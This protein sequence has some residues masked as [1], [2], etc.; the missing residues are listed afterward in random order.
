MEATQYITL[1]SQDGQLT[2]EPGFLR[3]GMDTNLRDVSCVEWLTMEAEPSHSD[4]I[5]IS[6]A[7]SHLHF[8]EGLDLFCAKLPCGEYT[9]GSLLLALEAAMACA[10]PVA[11]TT[12]APSPTN[13]Y[14]FHNQSGRLVVTA[15]GS[16]PFALHVFQDTVKILSLRPLNPLEAHVTFWSPVPEPMAKGTA[17]EIARPGCHPFVAQVLYTVGTA[18][19]IRCFHPHMPGHEVTADHRWIIRSMGGDTGL[20]RLLGLGVTDLTSW[21]PLKLV[22]S[23]NVMMPGQRLIVGVQSPHGRGSASPFSRKYLLKKKGI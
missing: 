10:R 6:N 2:R 15:R 19:I 14:S 11:T 12:V 3:F 9:E 5:V 18:M 17:I 23:S 13:V 1:H 16:K 22:Q 4:A 20:P 21:T 8:S 7:N